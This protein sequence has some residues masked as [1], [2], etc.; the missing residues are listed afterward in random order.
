MLYLSGGRIPV[1]PGPLVLNTLCTAARER[2]QILRLFGISVPR[3]VSYDVFSR[4]TLVAV[5]IGAEI[6]LPPLFL[7]PVGS[8]FCVDD[9]A[10]SLIGL[11][12]TT[13]YSSI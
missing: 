6:L 4:V 11:R 2:P 10:L 7:W 1:V 9:W 3:S 12:C 8:L 5:T 13:R